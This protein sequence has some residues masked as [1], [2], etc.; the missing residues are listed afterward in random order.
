M[1]LG[2]GHVVWAR[3]RAYGLS[4]LRYALGTGTPDL[5]SETVSWVVTLAFAGVTLAAAAAVAMRPETG[6][7]A[8][9]KASS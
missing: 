2:A 8:R 6:G 9:P 4:A 7:R 5:P 1:G 3:T